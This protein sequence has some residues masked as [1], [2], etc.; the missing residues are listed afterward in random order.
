MST[1]TSQQQQRDR[2]AQALRWALESSGNPAMASADWLAEDIDPM[3]RSAV[4]LL[5]DPNVELQKLA[6]AK[7]VFK[8]M[9]IVGET[10]ADRHIGARLYAAAIAAALARHGKRI[11]TQSE[12]ALRRGFQSLLND[13][14]MP[15][16][17][18][19]LAGLG[20]V[21]LD[22]DRNRSLGDSPVVPA[23]EA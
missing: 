21:V 12:R 20:L 16:E 2:L 15:K 8:T 1:K 22:N 14:E 5:T 13:K 17:L 7:S 11:S 23:E 19:D 3:H 10:P 18:R 6:R 4:Q 9:R